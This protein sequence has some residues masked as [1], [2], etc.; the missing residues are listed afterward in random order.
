MAVKSTVRCNYINAPNH[1]LIPVVSQSP[2][3]NHWPQQQKNPPEIKQIQPELGFM[4][5]FKKSLVWI[6]L[7]ISITHLLLYLSIC[8]LQNVIN[9]HCTNV[10]DK[11]YLYILCMHLMINTKGSE[12]RRCSW[13][14]WRGQLSY[15]ACYLS[16]PSEAAAEVMVLKAQAAW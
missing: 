10:T 7:L 8:H 5:A 13:G 9:V 4:F 1:L 3:Q 6:P 15:R 14:A 16:A 11:I 2:W 12:R